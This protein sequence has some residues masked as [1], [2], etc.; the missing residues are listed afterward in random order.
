MANANNYI[1]KYRV[2]AELGTGTFGRVYK[3]QHQ[4][5]TSRIVAIKLMHDAPI[6]SPQERDQFLQE[7]RILEL[8]KSIYSTY[9]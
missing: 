2:I 1:G 4:F 3:A 8:L 5:L 7:A 9:Y 6:N